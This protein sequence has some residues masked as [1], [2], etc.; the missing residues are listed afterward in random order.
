MTIKRRGQRPNSDT[1][2]ST[3][4]VKERTGKAVTTKCGVI[5]DTSSRQPV[6]VTMWGSEVTCSRCVA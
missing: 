2:L 5:A 6:K 4:M 1:P 3:H